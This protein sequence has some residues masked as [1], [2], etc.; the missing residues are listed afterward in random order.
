M[1][2]DCPGFVGSQ[3][4]SPAAFA[5]TAAGDVP[6]SQS[7][8]ASQFGLDAGTPSHTSMLTTVPWA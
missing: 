4:T 6:L 7:T 2:K 1:S 8:D 3:V 5:V